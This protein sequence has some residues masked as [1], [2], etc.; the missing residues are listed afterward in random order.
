MEMTK[1]SNG[2]WLHQ[3]FDLLLLVSIEIQILEEKTKAIHSLGYNCIDINKELSAALINIPPND[4]SRAVY[5]WLIEALRKCQSTPVFLIGI[6][7]LFLPSLQLDP[8]RLLRDVARITPLS[9]LWL[10]EYSANTLTYAIPEHNHYRSWTL[11]ASLL[12]QP[13]VV[14]HSISNPKGE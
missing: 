2:F 5:P 11:N 6:D 7:L 13:K 1:A 14:I 12:Q 3:P 9:V 10:G 4:R 8:F